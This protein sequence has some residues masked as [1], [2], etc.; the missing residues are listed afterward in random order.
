MMNR[1]NTDQSQSLKAKKAVILA[2]VSSK[3]Q[4]EGYSIDAQKHRLETYCLRR[5]LNVLKVF[6]ITESSTMG[7]RRRFMAMI[8]FVKAQKEPVAI[9][10]DKVDRVQRSFK[11]YPLLD[12]LIQKGKIELHFNTE[13]YIIH[14][15]SVS[16]ERLM[17]SMGVIM[18]QSYIDSMRD[19]VKRSFDQKIRQGEWIAKAPLGYLNVKDERGRSDIVLDPDAAPLV[20]K[21]FEEY[22][23]GAFTISEMVQKAKNWGLRNKY[24][25]KSYPQKALV[26]RML[27]NPFYYGQMQI[28]GQLYRHRYEPL[29][30]KA[31]FDQCQSVL[32]GCT[33][34]RFNGRARN[35]FSAA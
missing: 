3:E 30:S 10:A 23:T 35:L 27:T 6:E 17:W 22:A 19:N 32:K 24:G 16:Q 14:K 13:N 1:L 9:V 12:E 11:E 29:V 8:K 7:D 2:R 4:E 18:A 34:S 20:K 15:D 21:L 26:H 25:K 31:V 5:N 33:K 28:K